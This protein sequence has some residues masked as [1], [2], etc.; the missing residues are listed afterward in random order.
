[1]SL[2][3]SHADKPGQIRDEGEEI[4]LK[5]S[6]LDKTT[7]KLTWTIPPNY[8]GCVGGGA[9]NGIVIT[10]SRV[11]ANYISS[12]PTDGQYYIGD[13]TVDPDLHAGSIIEDGVLVL[14]AFYDDTI[15]TELEVYGLEDQVPYYFSA[16]A[17]DN[18]ARYHR[19][20]VHSYS[21]PTGVEE[22]GST[23]A[24]P[25]MHNVILE[26]P[27]T[28]TT[29]TKLDVKKTYDLEFETECDN[30]KISIEGKYA[31]NYDNLV[32]EINYQLALLQNPYIS[33]TP[34]DESGIFREGDSFY[35]WDG[36][37]KHKL[38]YIDSPN[39][40]TS[41]IIG[42]IWYNPVDK[43]LQ[44][45]ESGGWVSLNFIEFEYDITD[46]TT[47]TYWFDGTTVRYWCVDK[48]CSL[49]TIT[50]TKNPLL[51]NIMNCSSYWYNVNIQELYNWDAD[52]GEW[53]DIDALYYPTDPN[54]ISPGSYWYNETDEKVY[55]LQT[56]GDG[57]KVVPNVVYYVD[58]EVPAEYEP[59]LHSFWY[60]PST[61]KLQKA[62]GYWS[63]INLVPDQTNPNTGDKWYD[64]GEQKVLVYTGDS[65]IELPDV[66]YS[67]TE[68]ND[69]QFG[70]MWFNTLAEQ[71]NEYKQSWVLLDIAI[72]PHDP[73]DRKSCEL[74]WDSTGSVDYLYE[75]DE[76]NNIW[77]AVD[78][79]YK[80][81]I[82]PALP[83]K[84][85]DGSVWYNPIT[86]E[87]L[88]ILSTKCEIMEVVR[89]PFDPTTPPLG[90]V[91]FAG[92][93]FYMWNGSGWIQYDV[94]I[95]TLDPFIITEETY[96]YDG[97]DLHEWNGLSWDL[98][99]VLDYDPKPTEGTLWLDNVN[100]KLY[101]WSVDSW[102]LTL[103]DIYSEFIKSTC[104]TKKDILAFKTKS[105]G[106]DNQLS[107]V[108]NGTSVLASL[109]THIRYLHP[110]PGT[111]LSTGNPM[112]KMLGVGD[113][114][115]PDERRELQN[116]I[117]ELLGDPGAKV[118]LT[119]TQLNICIDN[120]V[121]ML[122]KY[123]GHAYKRGF[124]FLDL[125]P[126]QQIYKLTDSCVGFNTIVRVNEVH[127][128]TGAFMGGTYSGYDLYGYAALQQLYTMSTFDIL[129][130]HLVSSFIEELE[131]LFATRI[132]FQWLEETRE[133]KLYNGVYHNE[134]VLIDCSIE[135]TEQ[136][137]FRDRE[138]EIWI[139]RWAVAEAKMILSQVRG[140]FQ[141]LPGPS[142]S[143]VLNSQ[144][145]I[146]QSESEKA[147]LM[148][149]LE[150]MSMSGI[151]EVG[152][153]GYFVMG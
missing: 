106:C 4:T 29:S 98:I 77:V 107:I 121:K 118:E 135:R 150:D 100:K 97:T 61:Q 88:K 71:L 21:L 41:P 86:G 1:M 56:G 146:T 87:I 11:P 82:D 147:V 117:R 63:G 67:Q 53:V 43:T 15:T 70:I 131:N 5:Y 57:W 2:Y 134:R 143:T 12:S 25:A 73:L 111:A 75:W 110:V 35:L 44:V 122:R 27:T 51:P 102:S 145:L 113:D 68:P 66:I 40:P 3:D 137:L 60:D 52:L 26:S 99:A 58:G 84:L 109:G 32:R 115:S 28:L 130:F 92:T 37:N 74:W 127:R 83:E 54:T 112:Y 139:Q 22:S 10:V 9:Y 69:L 36:H 124:F 46:P 136:D 129:S 79:F 17:V 128:M 144:E 64:S 125:Y 30:V 81:D 48:W 24:Y 72:Y 78:K 39:D 89:T 132:T 141:S 96:W 85:P 91:W 133:L 152:L 38:V 104:S 8:K 138:T 148:E 76:V 101:M 59:T 14:G 108:R 114:G 94:I 65:W 105:V 123:G 149:E 49:N 6:R 140:K 20:G 7:G 13:P 119:K 120:A 42:T 80:T 153:G 47:Y 151:V 33:P 126:N 103:P 62:I 31:T 116:T 95:H 50:S 16:Y 142:G 90:Y 19:E 93:A 18:V 23:D 34:P 45:Y 55:V